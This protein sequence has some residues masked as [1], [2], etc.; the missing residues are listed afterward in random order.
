MQK[1]LTDVKR[2]LTSLVSFALTL[3]Y[4]QAQCCCLLHVCNIDYPMLSFVM[5]E[6]VHV[7]IRKQLVIN[8]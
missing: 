8:I 7:H 2:K 3:T 5:R 4:M 1:D 6:E